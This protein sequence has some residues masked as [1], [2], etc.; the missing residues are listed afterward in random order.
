MNNEGQETI[1]LQHIDKVIDE[2]RKAVLGLKEEIIMINGRLLPSTPSLKE[3]TP[4]EKRRLTGWV[5]RTEDNLKNILEI[6]NRQIRIQ[7]VK[8]LSHALD[9]G[10]ETTPSLKEEVASALETERNI[11]AEG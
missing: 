2:I 6:V 3:K 5:E 11:Q 9:V 10:R 8:R 4:E 7:E 1:K